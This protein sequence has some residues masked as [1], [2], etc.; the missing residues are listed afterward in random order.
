MA[1][2]LTAL[3]LLGLLLTTVRHRGD[4]WFFRPDSQTWGTPADY[5]LDVETVHFQAPGG[6]RLHGW[7]IAA[8]GA[9]RGTV[10]YCHGNHG[11]LTH[12]ARF[13]RWLPARGYNVL[14]FDY[15]GY[16]ESAG[17]ITRRGAIDDAIAAI[18]FALA[19]DPHRTCLFGHSLGGAIGIGAATRRPAVRAVIAEST[20][21]SYRAAARG[22]V[23]A[24]AFLVPWLVS[25]GDDP[26]DALRELRRPL[27]VLHG[28]DD[29]IV[30]A[31]LAAELFA[32]AG[33]PKRLHVF[34]DCGHE[35][36]WTTLGDAFAAEVTDFLDQAIPAAHTPIDVMTFNLRYA[37]DR[38]ANAWQDRRDLLIETIRG[39]NP[40]LIGTQEGLHRQLQDI[41][42]GLP[43]YA[44]IGLGRQGG[45]H[46]EFMAVYLRKHRFRIDEYDHFWLSDTP[47][48]I[49]SLSYDA[50]LPRMVTWLRLHDLQSGRDCYLANTHFDHAH[51]LARTRSAEQ[52]LRWIDTLDP[53]L[54]LIVT[55]DFNATAG[56]DPVYRQLVGAAALRDAFAEA[57]DRGAEIGTFHGFAGGDPGGGRIDWILV[58]GAL[59]AV[60]S[61]VITH[62]REGQY[63]SDHY[64]VTTRLV[65]TD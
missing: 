57:T 47:R 53:T 40:D 23:P 26:H 52:L 7:W 49:G 54:P 55:G 50:D 1:K 20:F 28:A 10:V 62:H 19:R 63:P 42:V 9:A 64:P 44:R 24:L 59:S 14:I 46:D 13:I 32:A 16:G 58:R 3:L 5:G 56:S 65:L 27:L 43:E 8:I 15:R 33:E 48:Q 35:T 38:G 45:S 36:A 31:P 17:H 51:P 30:P 60:R 6:P 4:R 21:L 39:E 41:D 37:A 25:A 18:D 11:N 34:P 22:T 61:R 29:R 12:H 2:I